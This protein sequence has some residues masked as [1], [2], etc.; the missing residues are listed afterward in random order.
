KIIVILIFVFIF[1]GL[2]VRNL[3]L[4]SVPFYDWDEGMYAQIA[5]EI[6]SN[7]SIFTTFNGQVWLDKPPLAHILIAGTFL[8]FGQSEFWARM[9]MVLLAFVLLILTYLSA[10]KLYS[11]ISLSK[12]HPTEDL[13]ASLIPVL[14]LAGSPVFMD[15]SALLNSDTLIAIGWMG[16]LL[17]RDQ[18]WLKLFFLILGVWSKSVLGLYPIF[19]DAGLSLFQKQKFDTKKI[20]SN[21]LKI[22]ILLLLPSL[23]YIVGFL[24][25]GQGFIYNHF[26]SQVLK[27]ISVPIELH[28]GNKFYYFA[29][30]WEKMGLMN[31]IF[32]VGYFLFLISIGTQFFKEGKK[33]FNQK[34][35]LIISLLCAPIPFFIF[36]TFMKT[37]IYW[38]V[39]MF[40][41]FVCLST[42]YIFLFLKK[43]MYRL[44]FFTGIMIYFLIS[45]SSQTFFSKTLNDSTERIDLAKCIAKTSYGKVAFLVDEDERKVRNVLEAAHYDT[46]SSFFYGGS[47][48]FVYYIQRKVDYFYFVEDFIQKYKQ[49]SI[50]I[51]SKKDIQSNIILPALYLNKKIICNNNNW[52]TV[53]QY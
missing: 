7:K 6:I 1:I 38:Y 14:I 9:S 23:W 15:R 43:K 8:L 18:Y 32:L 5:K 42:L 21:G 50:L 11:L 46:T 47:P 45:F 39:I 35:L 37:K 16:Y 20:F 17:Y 27:R 49:Y 10:K 52:L 36:L 48:S 4:A 22:L 41:P 25:Y 12:I 34:N 19:I 13:M 28:I 31:I 30:L 2:T 26:Q 51:V 29:Y 3:H 53:V 24:K 44:L 40:F 33:I